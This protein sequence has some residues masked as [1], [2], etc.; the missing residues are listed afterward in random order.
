MI[1]KSII[2]KIF[3]AA[4]AL[5]VFSRFGRKRILKIGLQRLGCL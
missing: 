1:L 3:V 4:F 2:K 5:L